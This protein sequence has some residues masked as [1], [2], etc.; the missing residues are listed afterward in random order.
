MY[1]CVCVHVLVCMRVCVH[2][3]LRMCVC[4]GVCIGAG[5]TFSGISNI[6]VDICTP[7]WMMYIKS[8]TLLFVCVC[9]YICVCVCVCVCM[10]A[11]VCVFECV[12][13]CV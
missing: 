12:R 13:V 5:E 10:C 3:H 9:V 8:S 1:V 6:R 7:Q 4:A 11:C 2:I